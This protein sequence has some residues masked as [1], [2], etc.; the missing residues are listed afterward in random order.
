[1]ARQITADCEVRIGT[2]AKIVTLKTKGDLEQGVT[3]LQTLV[4]AAASVQSAIEVISAAAGQLKAFG[5]R[6]VTIGNH[7]LSIA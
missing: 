5:I 7:H 2:S 1:M 4:V 6:A 3:A